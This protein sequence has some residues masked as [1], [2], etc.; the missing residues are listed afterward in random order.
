MSIVCQNNYSG[1][2]K[3]CIS[4]AGDGMDNYATVPANELEW[5]QD[6]SQSMI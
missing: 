3:K 2:D 6:S 1:G 4:E 5:V